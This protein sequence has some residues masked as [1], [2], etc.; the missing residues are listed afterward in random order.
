[1][2]LLLERER[3]RDS[4]WQWWAQRYEVE[5]EEVVAYGEDGPIFYFSLFHWQIKTESQES[6]ARTIHCF[7]YSW[8]VFICLIVRMYDYEYDD[9]HFQTTTLFVFYFSR[10]L[11]LCLSVGLRLSQFFLIIIF[12]CF[13][14]MCS[15][16][17]L[18]WRH[19]TYISF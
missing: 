5:D 12:F 17:F 9:A 7:I 4:P 1:M 18:F 10:S 11:S 6:K 3:G 15:H 19:F 2:F 8:D 13:K 16:F 14:F